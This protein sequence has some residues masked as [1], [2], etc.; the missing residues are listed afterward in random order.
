MHG[1]NDRELKVLKKLDS[2][3]KI[4]GF[5][6]TLRKNFEPDGD[7]CMSPRVVLRKGCCHCIEGAMLACA[8]MRL[9]GRKPLVVDL[10]AS[11]RDFDHVIA[12]FKENGK[13]GAISKTNYAV[14]RYREPVYNS[15]RELVM[16][17]FHEYTDSGG[18]KTLRSYSD[19][20][21]LS[22]LDRTGWMTS[23]KDVWKVPDHLV[24][25]RHHSI[26]NRS[27]IARLRRAD[28]IEIKAG[29]LLEW[30][31]GKKRKSRKHRR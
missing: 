17:Y 3:R 18:R 29:K 24:K 6:D 1:F 2:P 16:S 26:L 25:V 15:V 21:D 22:K 9:H 7:S 19:P 13:W 27:Q 5:L 10:T 4:Q 12:V 20:V 28:P 23:E 31:Q 8:A 14:L 11:N 30:K